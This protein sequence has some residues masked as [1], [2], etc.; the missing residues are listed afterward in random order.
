MIHDVI[1]FSAYVSGTLGTS[2]VPGRVASVQQIFVS[3]LPHVIA[4]TVLIF[5]LL[6]MAVATTFQTRE[7]GSIQSHEHR[8]G[9]GRFRTSTDGQERE[10]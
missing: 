9:L 2:Y 10:S 8:C 4:S 5:L 3:S 7:G 6:V 1:L